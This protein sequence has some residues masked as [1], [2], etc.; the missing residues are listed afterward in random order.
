MTLIVPTNYRRVNF[1][2]RNRTRLEQASDGQEVEL[3]CLR[4]FRPALQG[5]R[6]DSCRAKR[7][8]ANKGRKR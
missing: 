8:A 7:E 5:Q 4:C 1:R 3:T 6:C 2:E